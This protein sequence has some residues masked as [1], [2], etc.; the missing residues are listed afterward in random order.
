MRHG[1]LTALAGTAIAAAIC[2]FA[3]AAPAAPAVVRTPGQPA[4]AA[5]PS[6]PAECAKLRRH[7]QRAE[8][9]ACYEGLTRAADPYLRAEGDWGLERYVDARNQFLAALAHADRNAMYRVRFG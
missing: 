4:R 3:A 5:A 9:Q 6:A 2:A 1:T 7:G 8:A